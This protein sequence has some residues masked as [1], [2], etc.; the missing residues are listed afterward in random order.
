MKTWTSLGII[1]KLLYMQHSNSPF[2]N[3]FYHAQADIFR[4]FATWT[5]GSRQLVTYTMAILYEI[6]LWL[7]NILYS[8][9]RRPN[10]SFKTCSG[11]RT[12]KHAIKV[13]T[14]ISYKKLEVTSFML[15]VQIGLKEENFKFGAGTVIR[16]QGRECATSRASRK[17]QNQFRKFEKNNK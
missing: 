8:L 11:G 1:S 4:F 16:R 14:Q 12:E 10:S 6:N 17:S 2:A 7:G 5:S 13:H 9:W 15:C 3:S